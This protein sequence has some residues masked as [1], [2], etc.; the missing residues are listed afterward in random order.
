MIT[1]MQFNIFTLQPEIFSSF[2]STSMVARGIAHSILNIDTINWRDQYGIGGY[3]QIDDKLY[4]GGSGMVLQVDPIFN[5]LSDKNLISHLYNP[6]QEPKPYNKI[7]PN[8]PKFYTLW[9]ENKPKKV[10]ISLTPRGYRMNQKTVEWLADS[11]DEITVLCGRYDGFDHRV[12]E[13]V[14]LE[15]SLGDYVL[16][17]GEVGAM[18]LVEAVARLLPGYVTKSENV[19]HDSFSSGL[20]EYKEQSEY[21]I[22]KNKLSIVPIKQDESKQLSVQLFDEENWKETV[23]PHI[24]HPQYTRPEIWQN[25]AIPEVLNSGDHKKIQKWRSVWWK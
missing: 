1:T 8:N 12:N 5:A 14:D 4:G 19:M 7:Y 18:V 10:S 25:L 3:K 6:S 22:G 15:L 23:L 24:E 20:N 13:F 11:F 2:L 16:N 9:L 21:V 17:G